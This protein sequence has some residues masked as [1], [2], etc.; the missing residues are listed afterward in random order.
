MWPA[1]QA[2]TSIV[3]VT[4]LPPTTAPQHRSWIAPPSS[5]NRGSWHCTPLSQLEHVQCGN[6]RSHVSM[7]VHSGNGAYIVDS[8]K[9]P[10]GVRCTQ[11]GLQRHQRAGWSTHGSHLSAPTLQHNVHSSRQALWGQRME[12]SLASVEAGPV[13]NLILLRLDSSAA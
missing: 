1:W 11:P 2:K 7:S 4:I 9:C 5:L 8:C 13:V 3:L 6:C 12:A 10:P